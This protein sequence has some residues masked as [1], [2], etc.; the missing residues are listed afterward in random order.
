MLRG[1]VLNTIELFAEGSSRGKTEHFHLSRKNLFRVC[2][3]K[4]G[5]WTDG[6]GF[7]N[8]LSFE[9]AEIARHVGDD[10]DG[11]DDEIDQKDHIRTLVEAFKR[12]LRDFLPES[13]LTLASVL[14]NETQ[15]G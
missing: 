3:V 7:C 12:I 15:R 14:S 13:S 6:R 9:A 1:S 10:N 2:G 8:E 5:G 11:D 4:M